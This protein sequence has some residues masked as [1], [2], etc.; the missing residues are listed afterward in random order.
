VEIAVDGDVHP[1][2]LSGGGIH[3]V[4]VAALLEDHFPAAGVERL[5]VEVGE[6]RHLPQRLRRT[7][8]GPDV[9]D[10]VAI[11]DE[12][13]DVTDPDRVDVARVGPLRRL[14]LVRCHVHDPDRT[15]LP[16]AIV[17]ALV[18]PRAGHPVSDLLSIGRDL[19]L[20]RPRHRHRLLHATGRGHGEESWRR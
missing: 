16:A 2:R 19:S 10:A 14:D 5:D 4:D 12:I 7:I 11:G 1:L 6:R 15:V 8:P 13:D 20:E 3:L 17:A 18:V 9:G